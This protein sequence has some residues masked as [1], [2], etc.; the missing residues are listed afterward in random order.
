MPAEL[1]AAHADVPGLA[2]ESGVLEGL[3]HLPASEPSEV[4]ALTG[5]GTGGTCP[6]EGCEISALHDLVVDVLCFGLGL[7]QDVGCAYLLNHAGT[8]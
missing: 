3:H 8:M 2:F 1:G 6:G 4:P 5:G 7:D